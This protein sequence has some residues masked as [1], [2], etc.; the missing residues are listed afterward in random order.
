GLITFR[1]EALLVDPASASTRARRDMALTV[2]HEI[3]HHW[4]GD[5]VTMKWWDD[6]WLNEG[7]ATWMESKIVDQWRPSMDTRLEALAAK[8]WGMS[9]DAL[10]SARA[11]RQPVKSTNDAEEAFDDITYVKG[12]S[13]LG[14][15]ESW[16]GPD[17]FRAGI[18]SYIKGHEH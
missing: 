8:G 11:V 4:F 13:V 1:E 15:L 6:I 10:Q 18:R 12:A 17:T 16:I 5:L 7:F 14:M 3:A 2:A 9:E